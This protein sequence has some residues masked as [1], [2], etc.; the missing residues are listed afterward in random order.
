VFIVRGGGLEFNALTHCATEIYPAD[1]Q[2]S[3]EAI[4]EVLKG[5]PQ[6]EVE[7]KILSSG[8]GDP[9]LQEIQV[10]EKANGKD[11]IVSSS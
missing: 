4:L 7:L 8:I 9:T 5:I 6:D 1:V 3:L 11:S 2:G 10:A